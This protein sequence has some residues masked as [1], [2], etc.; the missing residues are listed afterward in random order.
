MA[1]DAEKIAIL[2]TEESS[3]QI[4]VELFQSAGYQAD[5][6]APDADGVRLARE[7]GASLLVLDQNLA[8]VNCR[9]LLAE[10]KGAAATQAIPVMLIV[11]GGAAERSLAL[12]LGADDVLSRPYDSSELLARVRAQLRAGNRSGSGWRRLMLC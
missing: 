10:W 6:L 3:R 2:E 4:L 12:D 1:P 7:S 8:C 5:A 9:E 11:E